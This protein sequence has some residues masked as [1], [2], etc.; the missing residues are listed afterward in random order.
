MREAMSKDG[1]TLR[2]IPHPNA[3]ELADEDELDE[4]GDDNPNWPV[5]F[6]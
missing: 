4:I 1:W 5:Y 6:K 3:Q 2:N